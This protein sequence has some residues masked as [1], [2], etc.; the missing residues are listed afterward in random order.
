MSSLFDM[1][2]VE[3]QDSSGGVLAGAKLEFFT[4]GTSTNLDT[5]SDEALTS[6][7]ANPVVADSAG[8][9][10]AIF[11]KDK[12][13]KVT[14]SDS[15]DVQVW[16]ADPVH[17]GGGTILVTPTGSTTSRSLANLLGTS[18]DQTFQIPTDFATL[19][20]AVDELSTLIVREGHR[21]IL[22]IETGHAI[23]DGILVANGDYGHFRVTST[24]ATVK[25]AGSFPS[26]SS[27]IRGDNARLPVLACLF[28]C[29]TVSIDQGY[30]VNEGSV[31]RVESGAGVKNL[32]EADDTRAGMKVTRASTC[33]ATASVFT[34][35]TRNAWCTSASQLEIPDGVLTGALKLGLF[36]SRGSICQATGADVSNAGEDGMRVHASQV[37]ARALTANDC[38]LTGVVALGPAVID[39][40]DQSGSDTTINDAGTN[41]ISAAQGAVVN[42]IGA[43]IARAGAIGI[44]ASNHAVITAQGAT[45]ITSTTFG[46][47]ASHGASINLNAATVTGSVTDDLRVLNGGRI[48]AQ[49]STVTS[50]SG[51]SGKN[52]DVADC[53][54]GAFNEVTASGYILA[55]GTFQAKGQAT[56]GSGSTSIAVTHGLDVTPLLQDIHIIGGENPTADVGT[57]W[58]DTIGATTFTVNVEV[59]PSTNNFTFGWSATI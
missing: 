44:K 22:N 34:G 18:G 21:F 29:E 4:T 30:L 15:A 46:A 39:L 6:A 38:T 49:G 55:A 54:V 2:R 36:V 11:L 48:Y 47:E 50:T 12:D 57:I 31:G 5:F 42:A 41:G 56:I 7:N 35:C 51:G 17:G 58:V 9:W 16:S 25:L 43:D 14:L 32:V 13:Y 52:P 8:R 1:A 37:T 10:A 19:Q 24:D 40:R 3:A 23:T 53:N 20:A 28:D 27:I 26:S 33:F 59:D 45:I